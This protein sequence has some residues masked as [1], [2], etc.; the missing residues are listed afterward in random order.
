MIEI[1]MVGPFQTMHAVIPHMI[2]IGGGS[3]INVGSVGGIRAVLMASAYC[4]AKAG[5]IHLTKQVACD[6]GS[7]GIRCN[8]VCLGWVRTDMTECEMDVLGEMMGTDREGAARTI[9]KRIPVGWMS[10]PKDIAGLFVFLASDDSKYVNGT[11]IPIDGGVSA[12][13]SST[14]LFREFGGGE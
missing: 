6:Y 10:T 3:I 9:I 11:E 7:K 1:N 2:K 12:T 13:E 8:A 14:N 4:A 5:L